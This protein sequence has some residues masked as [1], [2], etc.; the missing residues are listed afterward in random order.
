MSLH[1]TVSLVVVAL[2]LAG[3]AG[4]NRPEVARVG[5]REVS[6]VDLRR[7]VALQKVLADLQGA[8]CGGQPTAEEPAGLPCQRVA[9]SNELLW[10]GVRDYAEEHDLIASTADAEQAVAGLEAQVGEE[11]LADAL[12]KRDVTRD[13]LL[14][15]GRQI[16]TENA[17][18]TAVAEERIDSEELRDQYDQRAIEFT[19]VDADHIL[20]DSREEAEQV[21]RRVQ[22]ATRAEFDAEARR[23]SIEPGAKDSGGRLGSNEASR[24]APEFAKAVVALEP[25]EISRPVQT[26]FG[27]HVIY[28]A[29]KEVTPFD[30]VD[31]A[32]LVEPLATPEFQRWLEEQAKELGVEVD[33]RFGTF[34]PSRF[35]V[36][37]ARSTDPDAPEPSASA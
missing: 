21:Y 28:L 12:A 27:W 32:D 14:E 29:D 2:V 8:P 37:A 18:R 30:E 10:L 26:Q 13:D 6:N 24:F 17:V 5:E 19:T 35:S 1:R 7:A 22:G 4:M 34:R 33:P 11:G 16:L 15:L 36:E 9:L 23:T 3:C 31:K 25:G 20:V